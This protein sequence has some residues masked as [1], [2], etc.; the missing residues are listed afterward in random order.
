MPKKCSIVLSDFRTL[1]IA[2]WSAAIVAIS[3]RCRICECALKGDFSEMGKS[4]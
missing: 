2:T 4:H 1:A 3:W